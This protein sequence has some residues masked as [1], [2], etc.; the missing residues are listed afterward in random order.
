MPVELWEGATAVGPKMQPGEFY[1]IRNIK[2]R[3]S[4]GGYMEG[5]MVEGEKI[6]KLDEDELEN[7]PHLVALL[8]YSSSPSLPV[9]CDMLTS[10]QAEAR[11]GDQDD[12]VWRRS[13]ISP[14]A[15]RRGREGPPFQL[16]SRGESNRC[17]PQQTYMYLTSIPMPRSFTSQP[18]RSILTCT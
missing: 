5:K 10:L 9:I 13:R 4:G 2:L 17:I 18:R 7:Q 1:S 14:S 16:Y 11:M 6:T 15:H 8:K 3:L 12:G